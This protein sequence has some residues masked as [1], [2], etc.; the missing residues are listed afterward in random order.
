VRG[1]WA[2]IDLAPRVGSAR[3]ACEALLRR[4]VLAKDTHGQTLRLAPPIV[5][6]EEDLDDGIGALTAVLGAS[7]PVSLASN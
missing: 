5:I 7:E 6:D 2:G 3:Q 4:G 1:L